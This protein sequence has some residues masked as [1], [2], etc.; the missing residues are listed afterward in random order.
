MGRLASSFWTSRTYELLARYRAEGEAPVKPRSRR[1]KTSPAAVSY[2][3]VDLII[4]L[5]KD[6]AG[7]GLDAG[8]Q[9]S[10]GTWNTTTGS[11]SRRQRSAGTSPG[12][13]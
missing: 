9:P 13:G 10:A 4:G 11:G 8:P 1:P 7:L 5:R 12:T 3:T 6:L 2:V